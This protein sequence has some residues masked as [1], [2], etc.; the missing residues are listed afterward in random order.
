METLTHDTV[1]HPRIP[2]TKQHCRGNIKS[3]KVQIFVFEM[4]TVIKWFYGVEAFILY[5]SRSI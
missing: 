2:N 4:T 3:H 5:V 1:S